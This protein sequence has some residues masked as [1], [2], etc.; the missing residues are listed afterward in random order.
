[1][2]D[3]KCFIIHE[4]LVSISLVFIIKVVIFIYNIIGLLAIPYIGISLDYILL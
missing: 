1:M 3:K 4:C 2:V